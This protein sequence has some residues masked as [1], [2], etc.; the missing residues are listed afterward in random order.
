MAV[1]GAEGCG[2]QEAGCSATVFTNC[3]SERVYELACLIFPLPPHEVA[4]ERDL[5]FVPNIWSTILFLL[6]SGGYGWKEP[7]SVRLSSLV[8]A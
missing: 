8:G 3:T 5:G 7:I 2:K 4:L 6:G 1:A